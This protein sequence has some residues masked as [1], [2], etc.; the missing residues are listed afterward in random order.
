MNTHILHL[1]HTDTSVKANAKA[2]VS[3]EPRKPAVGLFTNQRIGSFTLLFSLDGE[4]IKPKKSDGY[5]S[6]RVRGRSRVEV[7]YFVVE[8]TVIPLPKPRVMHQVIEQ[9]FNRQK[10]ARVAQVHLEAHLHD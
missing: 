9:F 3:A 7:G 8:R 4:P 10:D 5:V 6:L 1:S 2:T